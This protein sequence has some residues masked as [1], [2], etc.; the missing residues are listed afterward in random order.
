MGLGGAAAGF[1][2]VPPGAGQGRGPA[3]WRAGQGGGARP[4]SRAGTSSTS[5]AGDGGA[6]VRCLS[7]CV[8]CDDQMQSAAGIAE[9]HQRC[10]QVAAA[11]ISSIVL[12]LLQASDFGLWGVNAS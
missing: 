1:G 12:V 3:G 6:G 8:A 9:V 10:V 2:G 4:D 7:R 5:S 11:A